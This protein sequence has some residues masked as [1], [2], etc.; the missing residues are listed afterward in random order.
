MEYDCSSARSNRSTKYR[1][2]ARKS[3]VDER[4]PIFELMDFIAYF[5]LM[6]S[7]LNFSQSLW[8]QRFVIDLSELKKGKGNIRKDFFHIPE[9]ATKNKKLSMYVVPFASKSN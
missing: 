3:V 5:K 7:F 9:R 4:Y 2:I 1:K 6:I 8:Q